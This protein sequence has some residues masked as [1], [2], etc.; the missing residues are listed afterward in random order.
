M[1]VSPRYCVAFFCPLELSKRWMDCL[2]YLLL[3][4]PIVRR[5][6]AR[7]FRLILERIDFAIVVVVFFVVVVFSCFFAVRGFGFWLV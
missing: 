4:V 5:N 7:C 3:T 1:G 2:H 6:S